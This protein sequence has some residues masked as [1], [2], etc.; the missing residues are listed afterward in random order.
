LDASANQK[1]E[2]AWWW[3]L[4]RLKQT[5]GTFL[6]DG[7]RVVHDCDFAPSGIG[8]HAQFVAQ[9]LAHPPVPF[10]HQLFHDQAGLV[11]SPCDLDQVGV[12]ADIDLRTGF[13][14]AA[15]SEG[16]RITSGA[17]HGLCDQSGECP[18][19]NSVGTDHQE[20]AGQSIALN[21]VSEPSTLPLV[22]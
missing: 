15:G 22:T 18:F 19:A 20:R 14:L 1:D 5:I 7:I 3:F 11:R 13:A 16:G 21:R 12:A 4:K 9:P 17:Q 8:F 2:R 6:G 10:P